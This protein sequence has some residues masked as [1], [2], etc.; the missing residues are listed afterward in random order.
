MD[1]LVK[2]SSGG[3]GGRKELIEI[4]DCDLDI[5]LTDSSES[6]SHLDNS[7]NMKNN[8]SNASSE[9]EKHASSEFCTGLKRKVSSRSRHSGLNIT[10]SCSKDQMKL[11]RMNCSQQTSEDVSQITDSSPSEFEG[12][13]ILTNAIQTIIITNKFKKSKHVDQPKQKISI[14]KDKRERLLKKSGLN[15]SCIK[16][17]YFT[18]VLS[19]FITPHQY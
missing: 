8:D 5:S 6:V 16:P 10:S 14:I 19:K 12:K 17:T 7:L 4:E 3:N 11:Q 2:V 15:H 1:R 9:G 13:K 18:K